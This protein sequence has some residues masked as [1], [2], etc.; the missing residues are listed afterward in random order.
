MNQDEFNRIIKELT[1]CNDEIV[2][3]GTGGRSAELVAQLGYFYSKI[4]YFIDSSES[5]GYFC[6]KEI[7]N[8]HSVNFEEVK[9]VIIA[10]IYYDEILMEIMNHTSVDTLNIFFPYK[11]DTQFDVSEPLKSKC[12]RYTYGID[13]NTVAINRFLKSVG[14]FCSINHTAAIG[15][16]GNHP[17]DLV[18]TSTFIYHPSWGF[19]DEIDTNLINK[20]N[21]P[22]VIENDVWIGTNAIILPGV[23]IRNGAII[24]AGAVVTKEV[25]PY[26]IV[27]GVPAKIIRYRFEPHIIE[28]L[29]DI[30]WWDWDDEKIK[31]NLDLFYSIEDFVKEHHKL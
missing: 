11:Y 18:T 25:P 23:T 29:L 20:Y 24:G 21:P 27:G 9:G 14:S 10:S 4:S 13:S 17:L 5:G 30:K 1:H 31:A 28:A 2:I 3:Y 22:I 12:G 6:G 19:V 15:T 8:V 16:I 7:K 26:A